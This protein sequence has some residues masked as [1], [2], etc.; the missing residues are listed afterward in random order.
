MKPKIAKKW[1]QSGYHGYLGTQPGPDR[2]Q[3][4]LWMQT[5]HSQDLSGL[6][7]S[8]LAIAPGS[9]FLWGGCRPPRPPALQ[10]GGSAPPHPSKKSAFGL[11]TVG[12]RPPWTRDPTWSQ[13][14]DSPGPTGPMPWDPTAGWAWPRTKIPVAQAWAHRRFFFRPSANF[15]FGIK[16]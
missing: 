13:R 8:L 7:I 11:H 16:K 12:L 14:Q 10:W 9:I 3:A 1:T 5:R 2:R 4:R 6:Q 15:I